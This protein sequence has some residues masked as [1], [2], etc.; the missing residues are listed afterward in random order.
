MGALNEQGM[1][2]SSLRRQLGMSQAQ[3][4]DRIGCSLDTM[5]SWEAG[6]RNAGD[7][8]ITVLCRLV[9]GQ[10]RY[11][12]TMVEQFSSDEDP[13]YRIDADAEDAGWHLAAAARIAARV[14]ALRLEIG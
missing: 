1:L 12:D 13:V 7:T 10:D 14:P 5:K 6:R 2:I 4:A 9:E 8:P 11:V 3:A